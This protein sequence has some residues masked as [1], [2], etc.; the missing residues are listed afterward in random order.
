MGPVTGGRLLTLAL[1]SVIS[2]P[3][4]TGGSAALDLARAAGAV[5]AFLA[6][7]ARGN[8]TGNGQGQDLMPAAEA[9]AAAGNAVPRWAILHAVAEEHERLSWL[10]NGLGGWHSARA[11]CLYA[12]ALE[13]P[14]LGALP[15]REFAEVLGGAAKAIG[16]LRCPTPSTLLP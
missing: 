3:T 6:V 15:P 16:T 5:R 11:A 12:M 8:A 10:D 4:P 14:T 1:L 9:L 7:A 2:L 13:S